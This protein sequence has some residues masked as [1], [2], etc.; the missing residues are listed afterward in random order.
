[1]ASE[2]GEGREERSLA[3]RTAEDA[4][5]KNGRKPSEYFFFFYFMSI[6]VLLICIIILFNHNK[7]F[8]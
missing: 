2:N 1:M 4:E 7:V 3:G 5:A 8:K 6:I